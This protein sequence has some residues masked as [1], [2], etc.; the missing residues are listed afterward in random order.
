MTDRM[1]CNVSRRRVQPRPPMARRRVGAET[2]LSSL[3]L[4]QAQIA[5]GNTISQEDVEEDELSKRNAQIQSR[6]L[7]SH[8]PSCDTARQALELGT[9]LNTLHLETNSAAYIP[10]RLGCSI[11]VDLAAS[12]VIDAF[13]YWAT[14]DPSLAELA[15]RRY[16][17][18]VAALRDSLDR[19]EDS[20]MTVTLMNV[21]ESLIHAES[22]AHLAHR[23]GLR[24]MLLSRGRRA[25]PTE[26]ERAIIYCDWDMRYR[27]PVALGIPSPFEHPYWLLAEPASI[28]DVLPGEKELRRAGHRLFVR[29]PRLIAYARAIRFD[30]VNDNTPVK[31]TIEETLGL[32]NELLHLEEEN[33]ESIIL[34]RIS[35]IPTRDGRDKQIVPYSFQYRSFQ[36]LET[37]LIYWRSR[38][39]ILRLCV[40]L[41]DFPTVQSFPS[42]GD[43]TILRAKITR[44]LTNIFMSLQYAQETGGYA[45]IRAAQAFIN[46]WMTCACLDSW[47]DLDISVLRSW[48]LQRMND[49]WGTFAPKVGTQILEEMSEACTG[50][51]LKNWLVKT[52]AADPKALISLDVS[53][54]C[55]S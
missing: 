37:A 8:K 45:H 20:L 41:S 50:G 38:L 22:T 28:L 36:D 18:A 30:R 47:R 21:V 26:F 32:A 40:A 49:S 51:P 10:K 19:S 24:K 11:K 46:S 29:L 9:I 17:L 54:K 55:R 6:S 16:G 7:Q 31:P 44:I 5:K 43:G 52:H 14:K 13:H 15:Y 27:G 42:L 2:N 34:H 39:L 53:E 25:E 48:V 3:L 35:V 4:Q 23:N 33:A 12:A 1:R